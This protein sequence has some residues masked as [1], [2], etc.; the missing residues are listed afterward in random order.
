[1]P[2][3]TTAL[4]PA[5]PRQPA[6]PATRRIVALAAAALLTAC[7]DAAPTAVPVPAAP[8]A[9]R[10]PDPNAARVH[11]VYLVPT[12]RAVDRVAER[13]MGRAIAHLRTWFGQQ[14]GTGESFTPADPVVQVVRTAHPAAWYAATPNGDAALSFWRNAT[15]E[16]FELT[17]GAF[18][19][20]DDVWLY[21]IDADPA[22][23]QVIGGT[24]SVALLA[25]NDVRGIAGRRT[26]D[27]CT[28]EAE[29]PQGVC[30]WVGG[31]GH[32]M[33]HALGLPHPSSCEDGDE[34]TPCDGWALM[35][36]GYS[37]YPQSHV[38]LTVEDKT[39]LGASAFF[40]PV[41]VPQRVSDCSTWGVKD[42][43]PLAAA[44]RAS[45]GP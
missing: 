35:Y 20:A 14:L 24:S 33:G 21:Y 4:P 26:I 6:P 27:V 16:A 5:R 18:H 1:M 2:H 8:A 40:G 30:R 36:F 10:A 7:T 34:T 25:A 43:G 9:V 13:N 11:V 45:V 42:A 15:H 29:S 12:D 39:T 23:G 19:D 32:E 3:D 44:A 37:Q 17:G 38:H 22:C 41:R 31:L 28:G